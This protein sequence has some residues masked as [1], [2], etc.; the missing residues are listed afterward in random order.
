MDA[1]HG[2]AQLSSDAKAILAALAALS[3][4]L[5]AAWAALWSILKKALTAHQL[6][7]RE[8]R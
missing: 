3:G 4:V 1:L 8:A 6:Y 7:P 5:W 2:L